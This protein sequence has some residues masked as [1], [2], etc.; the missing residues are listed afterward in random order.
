[1]QIQRSSRFALVCLQWVTAFWRLLFSNTGLILS[2][3]FSIKSNKKMWHVL[4]LPKWMGCLWPSDFKIMECTGVISR[5]NPRK[6]IYTPPESY[7]DCFCKLL[8]AKMCIWFVLVTPQ[9]FAPSRCS[10]NVCWITGKGAEGC[11]W[12]LLSLEIAGTLDS[13]E[14]KSQH[15]PLGPGCAEC[16]Q[17]LAQV[18]TPL[19]N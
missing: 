5:L 17:T 14:G 7:W 16:W 11:A 1:M 9:L 6:A 18:N 19:D 15:L 12:A 10:L 2:M 3:R 8:K 13:E 4:C